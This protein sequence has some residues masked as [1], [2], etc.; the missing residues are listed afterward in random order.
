MPTLPATQQLYE[1]AG[2]QEILHKEYGVTPYLF[3]SPG[4][5]YDE[6]TIQLAG[7]AGLKGVVMWK[8]AMEITDMEYQTAAHRLNRGTSSS[9]ISASTSMQCPA[10]T[11]LSCLPVISAAAVTL[12]A[13]GP[14][15]PTGHR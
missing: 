10:R 8:E 1:I 12:T 2:Q 9:P 3:R 13:V 4:G 14:P 5:N 11:A 6:T 15:Q 7:E